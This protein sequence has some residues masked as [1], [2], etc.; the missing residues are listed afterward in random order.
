SLSTMA[1][2]PQSAYYMLTNADMKFPNLESKDNAELT[3]AN[4]VNYLRDSDVEVRKEA[5]NSYYDV[6]AG[7]ENTISTLMQDNVKNLV[8]EAKL[9][10][11]DSAIQMELFKDDVDV[12]VY[13]NLIKSVR[14]NLEGLH[15]YYRLKKEALNLDEQHMYD[16]YL[17]IAGDMTDEITYEKAV[18]TI[19]E[20]RK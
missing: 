14:E 16:V 12:K 18:D 9:R 17:P 20:A 10:S 1:Q 8:T 7:V 4:F 5:F 13:E 2:A 3:N 11:Y 15:E 19:K 6:Y